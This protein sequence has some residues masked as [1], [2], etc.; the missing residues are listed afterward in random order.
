MGM[1]SSSWMFR[2]YVC[3]IT[4]FWFTNKHCVCLCHVVVHTVCVVPLQSPSVYCS[5]RRRALKHTLSRLSSSLNGA[6]EPLYIY[7]DFNFRLDFSGVIKVSCMESHQLFL[8]MYMW[9][10]LPHSCLLLTW[11]SLPPPQH[12]MSSLKNEPQLIKENDGSVVYRHTQDPKEVIPWLQ[13]KECIDCI[14]ALSSHTR[15]LWKWEEND[16]LFAMAHSSQ[17]ST[18]R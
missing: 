17:R 16:F 10:S 18:R 8:L 9:W 14:I 11:C 6:S 3:T 12:I 7:G 15:T 13:C 2:L 4:Y 5:Y 1:P